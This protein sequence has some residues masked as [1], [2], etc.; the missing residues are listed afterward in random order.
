[1]I[2]L[3]TL[4]HGVWSHAG[5]RFTEWLGAAPLIGI[6]YVLF[7]QPGAMTTTPSFR[8]L[9]QWADAAVW[10]N[11]ILAVGI[12]RLLALFVN[13][14][15][16]GFQHSPAIRFLASCAASFFWMLFSVGVF[17]AWRDS[18]G[19]PTGPVVYGTL[20]LLEFRNAYVS[21]VDMAVTRGMGHARIDR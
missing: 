10:A 18:G 17:L 12:L 3:R 4:A 14:S 11:I 16:K 20:L 15:F 2:V 13:G 1:M 5:V 9:A 19:S 6:G 21:R 8:A 7:S